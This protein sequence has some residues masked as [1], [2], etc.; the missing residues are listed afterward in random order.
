MTTLDR[1]P[2]LAEYF[3]LWSIEEI[4]GQQ[5]ADLGSR[6]D[7]NSHLAGEEPLAAMARVQKPIIKNG[8]AGTVELFGPLMKHSSSLSGGTSTVDARRR[9]RA[10]AE[11]PDVGSILLHI[12][13]PGGTVAG[14][15]ELGDEIAKA[16]QSKRVVAFIEDL[17][18]SAAYWLAS[19]AS[20]IYANE[21]AQVGSIG[22]YLAV[23]DTSEAFEKAGVKTHVIRAG[24]F[25][26]LG[27]PGTKLTEEHIAYLQNRIEEVNEFFLE[28]VA[29]G[30]AKLNID[31][32]RELADGK[33]HSAKRATALGLIDGVKTFEEVQ[34][35]LRS[36][37]G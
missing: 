5:L 37:K 24:E 22:T 14:T 15:K 26:G 21:T 3:G 20:E 23:R 27:M 30:R 28:A 35:L 7:I 4:A 32:V 9:V 12:E 36:G 19:Q 25:K 16:A 17:G 34:Q 8:D 13:S 11:D 1:V 18:A 31:Q 29:D 6:V 10:L 33:T 2:Y